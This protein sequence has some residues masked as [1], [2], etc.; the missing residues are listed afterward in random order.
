M[1]TMRADLVGAETRARGVRFLHF[2]FLLFAHLLLTARLHEVTSHQ[3]V[4]QH[5]VHG[6]H[7]GQT[8]AADGVADQGDE[9]T[10]QHQPTGH[11]GQGVDTKH[12]VGAQVYHAVDSVKCTFG[13]AGHAEHLPQVQKDRIDLHQQSHH[14]KTHIPIGQHRDPE[15]GDHLQ[16]KEIEMLY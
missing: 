3:T 10:I 12:Y 13:Q 8:H 14:C 5:N 6:S 1:V 4:K 2:F 11:P 9:V 16:T 15:T 7:D